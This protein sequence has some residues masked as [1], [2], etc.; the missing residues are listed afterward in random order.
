MRQLI[1]VPVVHEESDLGSLGA[2]LARQSGAMSGEQRWAVHK[3]TVDQFWEGIQAFFLSLDAE[4]LRL[5]QDGLPADGEMGRRIIEEGARRGSK[6]YEVILKLLMRGA[7]LRKTEDPRLLLR[8]HENLRL[9]LR[10]PANEGSCESQ[11]YRRQRESLMEERDRFIAASI[12]GTLREHELGVLFIGAYHRVE[13]HLP[14]DISAKAIKDRQ[15]V[16]DYL[17]E[18]LAGHDDNKLEELAQ[19]LTAPVNPL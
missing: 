5:Y 11:Q 8:E 1:Y 14:H 7:E 10:Q 6:N 13:T 19:A 2:S 15:Q 17:R 18:L 3:R 9:M 12:D 16:I 4:Q